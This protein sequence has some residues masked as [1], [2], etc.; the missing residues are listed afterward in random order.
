MDGK[1]LLVC[2]TIHKETRPDMRQWERREVRFPV[3]ITNSG[4]RFE[5]LNGC[6]RGLSLLYKPNRAMV[7]LS[8]EKIYPF[9]IHLKGEQYLFDGNIKHIQ[10]DWDSHHHTIGVHFP[11]LSKD[12]EIVLNRLIDPEYKI[13]ISN[14]STVDSSAG[15]ISIDD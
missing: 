5:S 4:S 8:L 1:P 7:S 9:S 10:Y 15:K 12:Q 11:H 2:S 13:T 3:T 14:K 6:S